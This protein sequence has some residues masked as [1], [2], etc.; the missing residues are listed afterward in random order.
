MNYCEYC[1]GGYVSKKCQ[2]CDEVIY[3]CDCDHLCNAHECVRC[4]ALVPKLNEGDLCDDCQS[5]IMEPCEFCGDAIDALE[6]DP[7]DY[8]D[9]DDK[10]R[11]G[12]EG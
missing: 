9:D 6:I 8:W 2:M 10:R 4:G 11:V 1:G 3:A 7:T 12:G 5:I